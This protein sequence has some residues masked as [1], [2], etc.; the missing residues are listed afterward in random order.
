MKNAVYETGDQMGDLHPLVSLILLL[1]LPFVG[2][3]LMVLG[4]VNLYIKLSESTVTQSTIRVLFMALSVGAIILLFGIF[5]I[6]KGLARY[7]FEKN[8]LIVKFP[9]KQEKLIPWNEFQQV[10]LCY[11]SYSS[12]G[13]ANTVICCVKKGE[14]L[15]I[16]G[17]WKTDNPFH[18][19]SVLVIEYK[20][21]YYNG[22]KERCP[23]DISDLRDT[24]AY[25]KR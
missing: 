14:K 2:L 9:F 15:N 3:G 1:W 16:F 10:C 19:H 4:V 25:S 13:N 5:L 20:R 8:G 6:D 17:R 18:C 23:Y 24:P 21:E 22:I 11:S 12:V 7:K